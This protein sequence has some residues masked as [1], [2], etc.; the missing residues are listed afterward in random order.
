MKPL[1]SAPSLSIAAQRASPTRRLASGAAWTV[2][3]ALAARGAA[4]ITALAVARLLGRDEFGRL[5]VV[6]S[7][8]GMFAV[9]SGL[10]LSLTST[11]FVAK[12]WR[13]DPGKAG[14]IVGLCCA[15]AGASGGAMA[16]G[17]WAGSEWLATRTLAEPALAG[18]LAAASAL[19]ALGAVGGALTG[20]LV[21]FQA[22]RALAW[23]N[24]ASGVVWLPLLTA[25]A[26]WGGLRGVVAGMVVAQAV[27]VALTYFQ[28]Q[29]TARAHGVAITLRGCWRERRVL[30]SFSLPALVNSS[31]RSPVNWACAALLVNQPGGYAQMGLLHA[32]NPWFLLLLFVPN[33]LANVYY[34]MFEEAQA[35]GDRDAVRHILRRS[36][37]TNLA[38]AAAIALVVGAAAEWIL[39]CYGPEYRDAA[40]VMQIAVVTGVVVAAHQPVAA[41]LI[42]ACNMWLVALCSLAWAVA[43]LGAT[44][45]WLDHGAAGIAAGRLAAYAGYAG[46]VGIIG[47][48]M[49]PRRERQ[50]DVPHTASMRP[51]IAA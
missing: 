18:P 36:M 51:S 41:Y 26:V 35:R 12:H 13:T 9:F 15:F 1:T 6:E 47:L 43:C 30:G 44:Y 49:L 46:L 38:V 48:G 25:G 33:Q 14:R 16:L 34:P 39:A 37:Q 3:G 22:Y 10:G 31:L 2:A 40:T 23:V 21:G 5:G 29:R 11:K 7:S 24:L 28:A 20:A 8:V 45:L 32:V 27:S 4:L 50:S 19:L 17:V 42:A